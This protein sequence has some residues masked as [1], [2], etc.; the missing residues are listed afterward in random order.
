[1]CCVSFGASLLCSIA[2]SL[3]P[4]LKEDGASVG[5]VADFSL[6]ALSLHDR[7]ELIESQAILGIVLSVGMLGERDNVV[8]KVLGKISELALFLVVK[9]R[10]QGDG[11][12]SSN[13][14]RQFRHLR[15]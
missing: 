11:S 7:S 4:V 8:D 12:R 9:S 3:V 10:T 1:M 14:D 13:V 15:R 6:V 5:S 2:A